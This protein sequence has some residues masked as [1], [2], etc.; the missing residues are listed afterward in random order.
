MELISRQEMLLV[1]MVCSG[2]ANKAG[3]N[4]SKAKV[5]LK[6]SYWPT[7]SMVWF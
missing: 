1:L 2:T 6:R 7:W 3:M 4:V 5:G